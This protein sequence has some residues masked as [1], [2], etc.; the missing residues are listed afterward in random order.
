MSFEPKVPEVTFTKN[1]Y[2]IRTEILEMAKGLISEDFR[3]KFQGWEMS[4][5]RDPKN[6]QVV[7]TVEMPEFPGLDK[8]LEAAEKMYAFVQQS[9]NKK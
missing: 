4:V 8:V 6:G 7:S 2:Q 9:S 1:G 3:Y 5:E